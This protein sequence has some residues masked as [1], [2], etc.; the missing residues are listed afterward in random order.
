[1]R[2]RIHKLRIHPAIG[3]ARVGR[4]PEGFFIGPEIPGV[5]PAP[6]RTTDD[7]AGFR[8]RRG[9][10]KRQAAR[11]RVFAYD[12]SD[13]LIGEVTGRQAKIVWTVHLQNSKAAGHRFER[14]KRRTPLRNPRWRDRQSLVLD[15]TPRPARIEGSGAKLDLQCFHFMK[16]AFAKPLKL[17]TLRID[18]G[19]RL[20]VLGGHGH[21]GTLV[22]AD[23]ETGNND[24]ANR[25]GWYDDMS[26]GPVDAAVT[27]N[28]GRRLKA[29]TAWVI[30]APPKFAPEVQSV[31][32]LYDT[33]YQVALDSP[34]LRR[35]LQKSN[36][37]P[38][39]RPSFTDDVYPI[40]RRAADAQWL[41]AR[42]GVGHSHQLSVEQARNDEAYRRHV[43]RQFRT[44]DGLA[45]DAETNATGQMPYLWSDRYEVKV[46]QTL[47]RHQYAVM[48]AWAEGDFVDDWAAR[49]R[50][51]PTQVSPAGLDR[52]ALEACVGAAFVP[53]I[54]VSWKVRDLFRYRE[55]FRLDSGRLRP[56]D[57]TQQMA[58]P[59]QSDFVD[60]SDGDTPFVWWPSHRPVDVIRAT[61][62]LERPQFVRWARPF[63]TRGEDDV[64]VE[65]MIESG[66]RLG[67]IKRVGRRLV[68]Y[69]RRG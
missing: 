62:P 41:F 64:D 45:I 30:V 43:F 56:G 40:L 22:D 20:L 2:R 47:T 19:G 4:S 17:G 57:V 31:V 34:R 16:R 11:F 49:R 13:K 61:E 65:A 37:L 35:Q 32:T 26:D 36:M 6:P 38:R 46:T 42:A 33:L 9:H 53:G 55:P 54:E 66:D 18:S 50:R 60:C 59:W 24:Y 15:P 12:K 10:L 28:D 14:L 3:I 39:S 25:D 1:M 7:P 51:T 5:A 29:T 8:D 27:L 48:K 23:L 68:E 58:V 63:S 44:P 52:A 21:A 69:D 67:L